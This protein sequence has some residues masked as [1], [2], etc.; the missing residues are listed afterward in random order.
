MSCWPF[1]NKMIKQSF[2]TEKEKE[3]NRGVEQ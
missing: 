1:D 3:L 2:Y